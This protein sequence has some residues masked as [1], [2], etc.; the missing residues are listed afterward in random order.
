MNNI[1]SFDHKKLT[2]K[3]NML[4]RHFSWKKVFPSPPA[5]QII[6]DSTDIKKRVNKMKDN[7]EGV[8]DDEDV[9]DN[10]TVTE[11]ETASLST[12]RSRT[13]SLS[14]LTDENSFINTA[15][16]TQTHSNY[17][18]PTD[19]NDLISETTVFKQVKNVS[20]CNIVRVCLIPT[21]AEF[22]PMFNDLWWS[23]NDIDYFK[24]DAYLEMKSFL[25]INRCSLKEGMIALYQPCPCPP[26]NLTPPLT[27][28]DSVSTSNGHNHH[29][30]YNII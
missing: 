23:V 21:R 12:P 29:Y 13:R 18:E 2:D 14:L 3:F 11:T 19:E 9:P 15:S 30:H 10:E 26:T 1:Q 25:E 6:D 8:A 24:N 4:T 16:S 17:R 27:L 5:P 7:V 28:F 20:F 22:M